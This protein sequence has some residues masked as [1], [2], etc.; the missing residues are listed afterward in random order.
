MI[1]R[2]LRTIWLQYSNGK[3]KWVGGFYVRRR[4]SMPKVL[5]S[6]VDYRREVRPKK[7]DV[8]PSRKSAHFCYRIMKCR[9]FFIIGRPWQQLIVS[10]LCLKVWRTRG[11]SFLSCIS[12]VGSSLSVLVH[13]FRWKLSKENDT[14]RA[15]ESKITIPLLVRLA[16]PF[17]IWD[18]RHCSTRLSPHSRWGTVFVWCIYYCWIHGLSW[19]CVSWF[20]VC[21]HSNASFPFLFF[22]CSVSQSPNEGLFDRIAF[23]SRCL[24]CPFPLILI[25]FSLRAFGMSSPLV[26]FR[27]TASEALFY[28]KIVR[29]MDFLRSISVLINVGPS[30]EHSLTAV[31]L[32]LTR[33]RCGRRKQA[34]VWWAW[35]VSI[36]RE[37]GV[38]KS[39]LHHVQTSHVLCDA[40]YKWIHTVNM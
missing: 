11:A 39:I 22:F 26:N 2:S 34:V 18:F 5:L 20:F 13:V 36:N 25:S 29:K 38:T 12:T 21:F 32:L 24:C 31:L 15:G 16:A 14:A 7:Q 35:S 9:T 3:K 37:S 19:V 28:T 27:K 40:L 17:P 4:S 6:L 23:D 1:D 33:T 8:F 10:P 30:W